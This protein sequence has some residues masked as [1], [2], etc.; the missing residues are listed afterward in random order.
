MTLF[1]K[2]INKEFQKHSNLLEILSILKNEESYIA[3][4][5]IR[6]LLLNKPIKDIDI[7]IN[8]PLND[9]LD[10]INKKTLIENLN[11]GP[12]GSPRYYLPSQTF[13]IDF[14]P[15]E[16]FI[17]NNNKY[18]NIE[19]LMSDFDMSINAIAYDINK[20]IIID[21][22]NG[23]EDIK[24]KKIKSLHFNFKDFNIIYLN[25]KISSISIHWF[26]LLHYQ[27]TLNFKF[28]KD[29]LE[30]INTNKERYKDINIFTELFFKPNLDK[31]LLKKIL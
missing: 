22:Y 17:V 13:Y 5:F 21:K 12:F 9:F 6:N 15:F 25:S 4:G 30:W 16:K 18:N 20:N 2:E 27:N 23:I 3:G 8:K 31:K 28:E 19:E 29:T 10:I 24:N 7:F 1:I 26:R 11:F 14:I